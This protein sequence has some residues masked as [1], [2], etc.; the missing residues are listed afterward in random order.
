M[1]PDVDQLQ[2]TLVNGWKGAIKELITSLEKVPETIDAEI[3]ESFDEESVVKSCDEI[4][5][6]S[7]GE[8]SAAIKDLV[9]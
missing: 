5:F 2:K 9:V 7:G 8:E 1:P 3:K 6:Y 4:A